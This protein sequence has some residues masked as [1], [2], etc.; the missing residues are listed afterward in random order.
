MATDIIDKDLGFLCHCRWDK[1]FGPD[2]K[3]EESSGNSQETLVAAL[4]SAV[5]AK[6]KNQRPAVAILTNNCFFYFII[7]LKVTLANASTLVFRSDDVVAV[8]FRCCCTPHFQI[9]FLFIT[10]RRKI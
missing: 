5:F 4:R 2:N 6:Y 8:I 7:G 10:L 1:V 9:C 3:E